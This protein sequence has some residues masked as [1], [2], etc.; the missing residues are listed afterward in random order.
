MKISVQFERK[1]KPMEVLS[2]EQLYDIHMSTLEV[3]EKMG[4]K[5]YSDEALTILE[6]AGADVDREERVAR[7]PQHLV[8]EALKKHPKVVRLCGRN[9]KFDVALDGRHITA[10]TDGTGL[11]TYDLET[12]E[13]RPST[14]EDVAKTALIADALDGVGIYYPIV[15][16]LDYPVHAHVVHEYE[17]AVNNTEKHFTSGDVFL[18]EEAQYL[19][20]MASTVV[21]GLKE[22]RRRPVVSAVACMMSPLILPPDQTDAALEFARHGVPVIAMT[23]PLVG[24]T[25]PMTVAGSTLV[26]NAQILA[27]NTV[28]QLKY[29]GTPVIYSSYTLS[30]DPRTG[31][32]SV[33]FP[34]A[35]MVMVGHIQLARYYGMPSFAGGTISSSKIP[36]QQAAYEKAL[37]G[38]MCM[39][40]GGDI[41]GTIGMLENYTVLSYEQLIIDY[42]MYTMMLK[43]VEGIQVDDEMLALEAVYRVGWEGSF[44]TDKHTLKHVED[45]WVP[46]LADASPYETWKSKGAKTVVERAKEKVM[47]ILKTHEPTPLDEDVRKE[48]SRIVAEGEKA[49]PKKAAR[50]VAH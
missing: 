46:I 26:G 41:C 30:M 22:L 3:L 9:P 24:S 16:S 15:T 1:L 29:P 34:E 40:A 36:D 42:E 47:E 10:D 35:T 48:L 8:E 4:V 19:I 5:V 11:W 7:I 45:S 25:G 33:A 12:G 14:K 6:E 2:R 37:C 49:I 39:L 32:Y 13:R 17:A 23:M 28:L 20:K 44:L 43:M 18:R 21:G 38:L 31:A 50:A 27:L